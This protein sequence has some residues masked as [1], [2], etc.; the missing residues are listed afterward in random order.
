MILAD[1]SIWVDHLRGRLAG[2]ARCLERGEVMTH[3]FVIGEVM[4][5]GAYR[6]PGTIEELRQLPLAPL[7]RAEEAEALIAHKAL[8]GRGIGYVDVVL[9]ASARL[10]PRGRLWTLDRHLHAVAREMAIAFTG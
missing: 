1:T 9:L 10:H 2:L 8:D 5:S 7:P 6:R 4:L 3:P